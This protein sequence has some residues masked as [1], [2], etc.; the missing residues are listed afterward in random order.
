VRVPLGERSNGEF[1]FGLD[2][3]FQVFRANT[4][5]AF[6]STTD[7][8]SVLLSDRFV[9]ATGF[10]A[11]LLWRK[12]RVDIR[13]GLRGDLYVQLGPSA[14]LPQASSV[15]HAFGVDPRLLVREKLN[16]RWSLRQNVGLYHQPR[17]SASSA[18]CSAICRAAS[19]TSSTSPTA[20]S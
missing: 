10:Y 9:S 19:A 20:S 3:E 1:G 11:E 8:V 4:S 16:E 2:Q 14:L 12:G 5:D 17:A 6:A 15:T 13:P 18:A 7:V